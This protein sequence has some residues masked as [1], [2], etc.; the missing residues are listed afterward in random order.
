MDRLLQ[1]LHRDTLDW[2]AVQSKSHCLLQFSFLPSSLPA[3][4][5]FSLSPGG[6]EGK[7][8]D[9]DWT[10]DQSSVSR[11]RNWNKWSIPHWC[12]F[13][14]L[15]AL[16]ILYKDILM[17]MVV[18]LKLYF[19]Q[20]VVLLWTLRLITHASIN[21]CT[22]RTCLSSQQKEWLLVPQKRLPILPGWK[23]IPYQMQVWSIFPSSDYTCY[24]I[25]WLP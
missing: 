10:A 25:L 21:A 7:W 5:T 20:D 23:V 14:P 3:W 9:F 2:S 24:R 4:P 22:I 18:N 16:P 11:W 17:Q 1:F 8:W 12:H 6:K 19:P 15:M 13:L